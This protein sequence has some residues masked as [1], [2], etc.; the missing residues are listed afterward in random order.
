MTCPSPACPPLLPLSSLLTLLQLHRPPQCSSNTP[1][2]VQPQ[3]LCTGYS[4]C[5]NL[6]SLRCSMGDFL[7]M[8]VSCWNLSSHQDLPKPCCLKLR[9]ELPLC[10]SCWD[11]VFPEQ[12]SQVREVDPTCRN[13][14]LVQPNKYI[15][16]TK[17]NCTHP[18]LD[19]WSPWP[20]SPP[21]FSVAFIQYKCDIPW[22]SLMSLLTTCPPH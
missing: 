15:L 8:F 4:L 11:S 3:G 13:W 17:Q 20:S 10:S 19:S 18:P 6:S 14:D 12:G 9:T 22:I 7:H 1:D 5:L 16:K 2:T 21:C